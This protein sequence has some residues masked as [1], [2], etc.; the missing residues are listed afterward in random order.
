MPQTA[1]KLAIDG[2]EPIRTERLPYYRGA[3][4][5]STGLALVIL[6]ALE[7]G[8]AWAWNSPASVTILAAGALALCAFGLVERTAEAPVLPLWIFRRRL[9]VTSGLISVGVGAVSVASSSA[10]LTRST[11]APRMRLEAWRSK[12]MP[13]S[14][15]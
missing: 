9:L 1:A 5:L 11:S 13:R 15:S 7:G 8:Q 3:A 4:L 12:A 2:G 6:G 14:G 10:A